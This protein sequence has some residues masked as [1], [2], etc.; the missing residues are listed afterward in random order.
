[1]SSSSGGSLATPVTSGSS[2]TTVTVIGVSDFMFRVTCW[3]LKP[4]TKHLPYLVTK[5]VT[6]DCAPI[7][8]NTTVTYTFGNPLITDASGGM[9]FDYH[10]KPENSPFE[11][12]FINSVNKTVAIIPAGQYVFKVSSA[13]GKSRAQNYIESKGTVT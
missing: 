5:D 7:A 10:F 1:M 3:G 8:P 4:N 13:D 12:K 11:T 9:V 2:A 6:A